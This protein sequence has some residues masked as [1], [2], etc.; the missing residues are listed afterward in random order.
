MRERNQDS[1]YEI[2]ES[3][4]LVREGSVRGLDSIHPSIIVNSFYFR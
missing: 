2:H 1:L 3:G 4:A